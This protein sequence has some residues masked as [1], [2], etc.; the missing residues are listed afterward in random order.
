MHAEAVLL[1]DNGKRKVVKGDVLLKQRMRADQKIDIAERKTIEDL[2][3]CGP[4]LAAGEDGGA[5]AGGFGE[6][7][8]G[9][10]MLTG[11]D[12]GRCHE[13]CLAAGF[14]DGGGGGQVPQPFFRNRHRL[15]ADATSVAGGRDR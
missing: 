14:D 13:G 5:D 6:R 8:N 7:C 4:A 12:F 1:V 2:F 10:E 9:R 11:K 3:S 15:A